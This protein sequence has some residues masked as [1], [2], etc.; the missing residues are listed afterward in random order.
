MTESQA[1]NVV[2]RMI[3][4]LTSLPA[5]SCPSSRHSS[6]HLYDDLLVLGFRVSSGLLNVEAIALLLERVISYSPDHDIW[7]AI[8][9]LVTPHTPPLT[10]RVLVT[11]VNE[12]PFKFS[13]GALHNT[14]EG[15]KLLPVK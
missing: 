11:G 2:C 8:Y 1:L 12:T 10:P 14:D 15:R 5:A 3:G 4:F 9:N 13:S 7:C 6:S